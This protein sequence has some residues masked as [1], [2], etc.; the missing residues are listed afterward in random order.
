MVALSG[1]MRWWTAHQHSFD[2]EAWLMGTHVFQRLDRQQGM[3][4]RPQPVARHQ[5]GFAAQPSDNVDGGIP[6]PQRREQTACPFDEEK[7]IKSIADF[8]FLVVDRQSSELSGNRGDVG[9]D[10]FQTDGTAVA[11]RS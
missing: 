2:L 8:W 7:W 9:D 6:L 4:D 11:T 5:E 1:R 3:I 10:L